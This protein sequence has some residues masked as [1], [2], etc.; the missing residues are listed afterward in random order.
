MRLH[1]L[2]YTCCRRPDSG[3]LIKLR[4]YEQLGTEADKPT[5]IVERT[6]AWHIFCGE[7]KCLTDVRTQRRTYEGVTVFLQGACQAYS[8]TLRMK[9]S[10]SV[11]ICTANKPHS[12]IQTLGSLSKVNVPSNLR[13]DFSLV[14]NRPPTSESAFYKAEFPSF[15]SARYIAEPRT[16][17]SY[18]RNTGIE[19]AGGEIIVFT[20]DDLRFPSDWIEKLIDPI[21]SGSA[22]AVTGLI[23]MA[24]HLER[25]WMEPFHRLCFAEHIFMPG[26][27]ISLIGA[28]MAFHR[29]V[30]KD[31]PFF[32]TDL[33]SGALGFGDDSLFSKQVAKAGYRIILNTE[34]E[35]IHHFDET[36]LITENLRSAALKSG[37]SAGYLIHHWEHRKLSNLALRKLK[38]E[39]ELFALRKFGRKV[40]SNSEGCSTE[41]LVRLTK[42]GTYEQFAREISKPPRY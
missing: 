15:A 3:L 25:D 5:N 18:A 13:V 37:R 14:D 42:R 21:L 11:I 32:D 6:Y 17:L 20:D 26:R 24:P 12:L 2:H 34:C 28:N 39:I 9:T 40:G 31:V 38:N 16:G 23:K 29:R 4:T 10:V 30:L 1:L 22:D 36:R 27:D 7:W 35:V 33:G 19:N 8:D 41:E